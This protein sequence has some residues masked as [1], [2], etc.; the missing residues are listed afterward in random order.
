MFPNDAFDWGVMNIKDF[1]AA[2]YA[3]LET[4]VAP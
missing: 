4:Q 3:N 2:R 1:A